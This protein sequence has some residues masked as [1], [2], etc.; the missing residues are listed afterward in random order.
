MHPP[1]LAGVGSLLLRN[2]SYFY[3]LAAHTLPRLS[4]LPSPVPSWE[5]AAA[6]TR[7]FVSPGTS[8]LGR[9]A[10]RRGHIPSFVSI[11]SAGSIHCPVQSSFFSL[12][13]S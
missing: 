13:S 9:R 7:L 5:P 10:G 4:L 6:G 2:K 11:V 3:P 8:Q 12:T 1:C